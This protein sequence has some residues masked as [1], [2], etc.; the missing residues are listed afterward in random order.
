M[1]LSEKHDGSAPARTRQAPSRPFSAE[2]TT[3]EKRHRLHALTVVPILNRSAYALYG[4][5]IV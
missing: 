4:L 1:Y 5:W 2:L 3:L